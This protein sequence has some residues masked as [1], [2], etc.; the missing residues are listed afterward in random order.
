[1]LHPAV[2]SST[3]ISK[4]FSRMPTTIELN[5]LPWIIKAKTKMRKYWIL[6]DSSVDTTHMHMDDI[7]T[8]THICTPY[9]T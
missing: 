9:N 6:E 5:D 1:M 2:R 3:N 4:P 8:Q 7:Y